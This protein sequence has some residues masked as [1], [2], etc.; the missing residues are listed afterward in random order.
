MEKPKR[1]RKAKMLRKKVKRIIKAF[2]YMVFAADGVVQ[3]TARFIYMKPE[4][5]CLPCPSHELKK[6]GDVV[7]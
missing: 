6:N 1:L 2:E 4:I 7:H 5:D 3:A